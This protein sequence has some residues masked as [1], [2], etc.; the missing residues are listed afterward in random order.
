MPRTPDRFQEFARVGAAVRLAQLH[1]EV[2]QIYKAFPG[3]RFQKRETPKANGV[4][5][6]TATPAARRKRRVFSASEK[7]AISDRMKKYWADRKKKP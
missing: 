1:E 2:R 3:L 5:D 6:G 7:K 4:T